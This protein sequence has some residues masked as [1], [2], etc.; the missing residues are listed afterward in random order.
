MGREL[1]D[2]TNIWLSVIEVGVLFAK[3]CGVWTKRRRVN[4]R[5]PHGCFVGLG[6]LHDDD[7]EEDKGQS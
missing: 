1:I 3:L 4:T 5:L 7:D 2:L 6:S